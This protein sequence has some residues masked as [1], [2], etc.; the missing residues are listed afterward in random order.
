MSVAVGLLAFVAALA[1]QVLILVRM[2]PV[3]LR[4]DE[5]ELT[6]FLVDELLGDRQWQRAISVARSL[7]GRDEPDPDISRLAYLVSFLVKQPGGLGHS[8]ANCTPSAPS[9]FDA[10]RCIHYSVTVKC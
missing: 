8:A 5:L 9:A 2:G 4:G 7:T 10:K 6:L 1:G 3:R